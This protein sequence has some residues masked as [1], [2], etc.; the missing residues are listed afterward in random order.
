[1]S[2]SS[3]LEF[4]QAIIGKLYIEVTRLQRGLSQV[5]EHN[6]ITEQKLQTLLQEKEQLLAELKS[7]RSTQCECNNDSS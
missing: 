3:D 4:L 5:Q 6:V 1:M 7:L 2:Q